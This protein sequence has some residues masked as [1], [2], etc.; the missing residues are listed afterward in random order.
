V[1]GT[2]GRWC[3]AYRMRVGNK[4]YGGWL[5]TQ[6]GFRGRLHRLYI[7]PAG[8]LERLAF[9]SCKGFLVRRHQAVTEECMTFTRVNV[10]E[11]RRMTPA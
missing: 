5:G 8:R 6:V 2:E 4:H 11:V 9:F 7:Y 3:D 10:L 1:V